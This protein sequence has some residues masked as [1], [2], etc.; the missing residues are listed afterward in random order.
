MSLSCMRQ[1]SSPSSISLCSSNTRDSCAFKFQNFETIPTLWARITHYDRFACTALATD[2]KSLTNYRPLPCSRRKTFISHHY[3]RHFWTFYAWTVHFNFLRCVCIRQSNLSFTQ[4]QATKWTIKDCLRMLL[5]C[6]TYLSSPYLID[7]QLNL[8]YC[9][10]RTGK[11][12]DEDRQ[13][14]T[15]PSIGVSYS[16]CKI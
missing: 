5:S 11:L 9:V 3:D 6:S 15:A 2:A 14:T 13:A 7:N 1:H 10:I 12:N 4:K 16:R 8:S